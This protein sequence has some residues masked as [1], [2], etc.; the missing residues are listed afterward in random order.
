MPTIIK[1]LYEEITNE[2]RNLGTDKNVDQVIINK[3]LKM[4]R[5]L[6]YDI[7]YKNIDVTFSNK[8]EVIKQ[9][10]QTV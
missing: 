9:Y 5:Y 3:L 7:F 10:R 6:M 2:L 8:V 4:I 1:D